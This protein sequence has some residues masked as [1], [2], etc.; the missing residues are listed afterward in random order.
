MSGCHTN[1]VE[2]MTLGRGLLLCVFQASTSSFPGELRVCQ[3]QLLWGGNTPLF[4]SFILK[5][6]ERQ[7][8]AKWDRDKTTG[9]GVVWEIPRGFSKHHHPHS[10]CAYTETSEH[11]GVF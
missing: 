9:D 7:L 6:G 10:V 2:E 11:F 1:D 4:L 5:A 8:S 3:Q